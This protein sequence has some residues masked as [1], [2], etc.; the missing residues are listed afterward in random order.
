[1]KGIKRLFIILRLITIRSGWKKA[2]FLKRKRIFRSIGNNCYYHPIKIPAEPHLVSLGDNVFIGTE[3]LLVTH[4]MSFV[5][6]NNDPMFVGGG[7]SKSLSKRD[8]Y[9]R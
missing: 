6:F 8:S 7:R 9:W 4:D 5:V 2:A 1:M 3:V